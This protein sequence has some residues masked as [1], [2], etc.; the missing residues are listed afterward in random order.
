MNTNPI[1]LSDHGKMLADLY[2]MY[3]T[4]T[5]GTTL[6]RFKED[7]ILTLDTKEGPK[8]EGVLKT[9]KKNGYLTYHFDK[10]QN[11]YRVILTENGY[12]LGESLASARHRY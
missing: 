7:L 2:V 9:L 5:A 6:K 4:K 11:E 12:H 3:S 8:R 10:T 1:F